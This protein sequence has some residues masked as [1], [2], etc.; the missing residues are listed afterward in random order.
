MHLPVVTS[1]AKRNRLAV[2]GAALLGMGVLAGCAGNTPPQAANA[3]SGITA[4]NGGGMRATG[5]IPD[6][7]VTNGNGTVGT[8]PRNP[9]VP[10][11]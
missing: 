8:M 6:V 7:T 9:R 1:G 3:P 5:A 10:T 2:L 11:Y 4:S